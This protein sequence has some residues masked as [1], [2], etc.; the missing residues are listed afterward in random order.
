MD[1]KEM[2]DMMKKLEFKSQTK[3]PKKLAAE[4]ALLCVRNNTIIEDVH[5]NGGI[6]QR[7]MMVFMMEVTK[8][9]EIA[10]EN[11]N[12]YFTMLTESIF[13]QVPSYW[14]SAPSTSMIVERW[15]L[16]GKKSTDAFDE[17]TAWKNEILEMS[18]EEWR[19]RPF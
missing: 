7:E 5:S 17:E 8:N 11:K 10:L 4:M 13:G 6:S 2:I 18:D 3:D 19:K 9:I 1:G 16:K 14:K 15:G 12:G